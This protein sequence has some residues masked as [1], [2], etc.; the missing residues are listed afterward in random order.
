MQVLFCNS[1]DKHYQEQLNN[2]LKPIFL[3]FKFWYD[4][5]LWDHNY[6]EAANISI[7]H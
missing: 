1:N 5:D 3:D 4:L 2:L 7:Q 6:G